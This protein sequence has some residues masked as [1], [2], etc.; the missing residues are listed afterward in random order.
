M[1]TKLC[2]ECAK[3]FSVIRS[4]AVTAK[5]CSTTCRDLGRIA[6]PNQTCSTCGA[7]FHMKQ[8]Q[9]ARYARNIGTFCS[10]KCA[11]TAKVVAY[12]GEKNPNYRGRTAD[13]DG[14]R[15]F[16]P[17]ASFLLGLKKM[18]LHQAVCCEVLGI[19]KMPKNVH[20]HHRDCDIQ[21]NVPENLSVLSTSDHKWIHKQ[22]GIAS[23]WA[24]VHG[25]VSLETL[26]DWAD[27]KDRARKLLPLNVLMQVDE[28]AN[29]TKEKNAN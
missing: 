10:N 12:T 15:L 24:Y 2:T 22:F 21:N 16:T 25:K 27:D 3:P 11:A 18:K 14:Y 20:I 26:I 28:I 29:L 8:S 17:Q 13:Q 6:A 9:I 5:Y 23:L 19:L 4:R 1:V 7:A